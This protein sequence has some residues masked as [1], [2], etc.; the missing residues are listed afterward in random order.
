MNKGQKTDGG[1][2]KLQF[3]S[4]RNGRFG[5]ADGIREALAGGCRWIQLRMKD[6]GQDEVEQTALQVKK[7][8]SDYGATFIIDDYV[9]IVRRVGADGVHLGRN[10]MPVDEARA[11]LGTDYIIGG[12][13][14]T[15]EDIRLH[16]R[17]GADYIGCGPFRFTATKQKLSPILG[18]EGYRNII[19][20]MAA[21]GIALPIVAIGGITRTDIPAIMQTGV[22]GIALSGAILNADSPREETEHLRCTIYDG[23]FTIYDLS[24][25]KNKEQQ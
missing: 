20:S 13:A 8:C 1:H 17:N 25:N 7:L 22:S 6:A 23:R 5:Y 3:I 15:I 24:F 12:T 16:H 10:D 19:S 14:N 4:H 11:I 2:F 9:E 18:I 21:E